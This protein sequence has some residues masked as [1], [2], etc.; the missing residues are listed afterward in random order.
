MVDIKKTEERL[1]AGTSDMEQKIEQKG[2]EWEEKARGAISDVSQKL[3][4]G[5]EIVQEKFEEV[6]K[7]LHENPWPIL[8]AVAITS[9]L[10]GFIMGNSR[11]S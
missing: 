8:A 10:L 3:K 2:R 6:D 1:G 5:Q 4:Q 11:R 9:L 7:K